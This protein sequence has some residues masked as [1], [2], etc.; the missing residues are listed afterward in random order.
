MKVISELKLLLEKE[1]PVEHEDPAMMKMSKVLSESIS[2]SVAK[3]IESTLK[4]VRQLDDTDDNYFSDSPNSED[5]KSIDSPPNLVVI[6]KNVKP[7]VY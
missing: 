7:I 5:T 1:R 2:V 4:N 3:T 6:N